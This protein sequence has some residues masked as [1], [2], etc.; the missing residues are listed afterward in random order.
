M[1]IFNERVSI[2]LFN[3]Y[4]QDPNRQNL[5]ENEFNIKMN[6]PETD[7]LEDQLGKRVGF[8]EDFMDNKWEQNA[9]RSKVLS[10]NPNQIKSVKTDSTSINGNDSNLIFSP[11]KVNSTMKISEF[12]SENNQDIL[13]DIGQ[14][15]S[16]L[17]DMP[18]KWSHIRFAD[19]DI[20]PEFYT[21]VDQLMVV[22]QCTKY[23][24]VS[25]VIT[26][27]NIMFGREWKHHDGVS[28]TLDNDTAP[29][30]NNTSQFSLEQTV[31]F[32]ALKCILDEI[33]ELGEANITFYYNNSTLL[34]I[35]GVTINGKIR[36]FPKISVA[37]ESRECLKDMRLAVLNILAVYSGLTAEELSNKITFSMSDI[38]DPETNVTEKQVALEVS[39][40]TIDD[41]DCSDS[42]KRFDGEQFDLII[43]VRSPGEFKQ[44]HI[45]GAVNMPVLNNEERHK[46]GSI[47]SGMK[48]IQ[49]IYYLISRDDVIL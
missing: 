44:D 4:S 7:F 9:K 46:V 39:R 16:N 17:E 11:T 19:G 31:E 29:E 27:A 21:C 40:Y 37:K 20:R 33:M 49:E 1:K 45:P 26:V 42:S 48:I 3:I 34:S 25:A 5:I 10:L 2:T 38:E 6:K 22:Y 13:N 43:D 24:A 8:C 35:H 41:K 23:Q 12:V 47:Y 28:T 36:T 30:T 14:M 15:I 32:V 18:E